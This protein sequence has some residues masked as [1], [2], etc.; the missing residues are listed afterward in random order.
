M[1]FLTRRD[2]R[3]GN[4]Y[5][6]VKLEKINKVDTFDL[7]Y[8]NFET[9]AKPIPLIWEHLD[10]LG[11]VEDGCPGDRS[12]TLNSFVVNYCIG[13]CDDR[14]MYLNRQNKPIKILGIHHLQNLYFDMT[15]EELNIEL[16]FKKY[17]LTD[18]I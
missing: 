10:R 12:W 5:W 7:Y 16:L 9:I 4:V 3:I 17:V 8:N 13:I 1:K 14:L 6:N 11:F 18:F 15:G 2:V